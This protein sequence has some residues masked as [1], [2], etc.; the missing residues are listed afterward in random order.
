MGVMKFQPLTGY[1]PNVM[2][3]RSAFTTVHAWAEATA[4]RAQ[5]MVTGIPAG[6]L[7]FALTVH[8]PDRQAFLDGAPPAQVDDHEAMV[9]A[10]LDGALRRPRRPFN[11]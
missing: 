4:R 10:L 5:G 9:A 11:A 7:G 3:D 6:D 2:G 8:G 1:F